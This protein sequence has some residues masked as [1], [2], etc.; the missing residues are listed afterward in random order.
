MEN[1]QKVATT[2]SPAITFDSETGFLSIEGKSIPENPINLFQ[3][4]ME[5][6]V[7]YCSN[8][9]PKTTIELRFDYCNTSSVKWIFHILEKFERIYIYDKKTVD[10]K[11]FYSDE[12][13]LEM[14][15]YLQINLA[16]PIDLISVQQ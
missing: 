15:K 11:F 6:V 8:P 12:N 10:I 13:T 7:T 4:L 9:C 14:G 1:M 5:E 3:P 2:Y 16:I